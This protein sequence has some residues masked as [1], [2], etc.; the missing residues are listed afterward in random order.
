[1]RLRN[2]RGIDEELSEPDF[3]DCIDTSGMSTIVS[4]KKVQ[5]IETLRLNPNTDS[6]IVFTLLKGM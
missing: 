5:A 3:A 4:R 1:M 2:V 6:V